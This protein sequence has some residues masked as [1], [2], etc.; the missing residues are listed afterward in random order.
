MSSAYYAMFHCLAGN[1]ADLLVG[2]TKST[3]SEPAWRQTYRALEHGS[4]KSACNDG[5][6]NA[7][8]P[9]IQDFASHFVA[10]QDKR[11]SADY[12]PATRLT[13]SELMAE[14]KKTTSAISDFE[15]ASPKDR[16]AFAVFVLF[17]RRPESKTN[18]S[19]GGFRKR[20]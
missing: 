6:I 20:R 2:G 14:I 8:P 19:T 3:R 4:A 15:A 11:H 9:P 1:C 16:R 12:D 17:K 5:L 7:F 18:A 10:M 13:K